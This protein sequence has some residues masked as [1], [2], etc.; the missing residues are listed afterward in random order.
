MSVDG[1]HA[2]AEARCMDADDPGPE[3]LLERLVTDLRA[4]LRADLVGIY[5][6][7]SYVSGGFDPGVSDLD[8]VAVTAPP[9]EAIDLRGLGRMHRDFIGRHPAWDDRVEVVYLGRA[10]LWSFRTSPGPLAVISPGEP[11]HLRDERAVE[12]LQNWYLVRETGVTL[13]GPDA[14]VI[15]PPIAWTEFVAATARYADDVRHRNIDHEGPG[16]LAYT[17]LTMCRALRTVRTQACGSKQEAAAWTRVRMPEWA[18]LI[19]S[20]LRCRLSRGASGLAD[21]QT[22][23]AAV[24]FIGLV[25]AQITPA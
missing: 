25:A 11:F 8:L 1:E 24:R 15:I 13:Y 6:Y 21:P 22:R 2:C 3:A 20:A 10:A 4:V 16:A 5:V 23:A 7:G 9:V 14:R 17:V 18:W 12:W 19:D